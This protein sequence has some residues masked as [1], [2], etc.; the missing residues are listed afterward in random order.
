[1]EIVTFVP[2]RTYPQRPQDCRRLPYMD[3]RISKAMCKKAPV[4]N[5]WNSLESGDLERLIVCP[6]FCS[7]LCISFCPCHLMPTPAHPSISEITAL[8]C[9]P[10]A[11]RLLFLGILPWLV[12]VRLHWREAQRPLF[13]CPPEPRMPE[14]H[15]GLSSPQDIVTEIMEGYQEELE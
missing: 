13:G 1:M 15:P 12:S 7:V 3:L 11:H 14:G 2:W 4:H 6:W 10:L 9:C 8:V 5:L